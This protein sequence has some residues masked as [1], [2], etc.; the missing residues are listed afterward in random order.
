MSLHGANAGSLREG[1]PPHTLVRWRH[2]GCSDRA[3]GVVEVPKRDTTPD[4]A[5]VA[6]LVSVS[7]ISPAAVKLLL[8]PSSNTAL[9][10]SVSVGF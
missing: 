8:R 7:G 10:A 9:D 1:R 5:L 4:V 6:A 3:C 2:G